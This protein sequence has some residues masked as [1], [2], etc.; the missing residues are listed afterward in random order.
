MKYIVFDCDGTLIDPMDS[1]RPL[2][3]GILELLNDL[4]AQGHVL[5]VWTARDRS[6]TL[7]ILKDNQVLEL[8]EEITTIDDAAPKPHPQGLEKMLTGK[9]KNA[10]CV[11]GDSSTDILGARHFGVMS[12]GALWNN[13]TSREELEQYCADF[14]VYDP[15]VCSKVITDNLKGDRN[16]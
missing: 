14:L 1:R 10:I 5:Y 6:S 2:Y 11:I 13:I 8:F 9:D 4:K 3:A 12:I 15:E 7:R 16:V